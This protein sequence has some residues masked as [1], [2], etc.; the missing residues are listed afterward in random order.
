MGFTPRGTLDEAEL[1][2][3]EAGLAISLPR[4]FRDFLA[5]SNGGTAKELMV[6][7]RDHEGANAEGELVT[8]FGIVDDPDADL[9]REFKRV[10][11]LLGPR[12]LPF[13]RCADGNTFALALADGSVHVIDEE[14]FFVNEDEYESH[15]IADDFLVFAREWGLG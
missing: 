1:S 13:G 5:A 6:Y 4:S 2:S 9:R 8:L 15:R 12:L 10:A 14:Q 3:L 11:E 7:W